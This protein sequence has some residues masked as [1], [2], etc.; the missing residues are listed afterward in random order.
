MKK[1]TVAKV[2][3]NL[4]ESNVCAFVMDHILSFCPQYIGIKLNNRYKKKWDKKIVSLKLDLSNFFAY[5]TNYSDMRQF[6]KKLDAMFG[7]RNHKTRDRFVENLYGNR[8]PQELKKLIRGQSKQH[9]LYLVFLSPLGHHLAQQQ[10][11]KI[12]LLNECNTT[13]FLVDRCDT[14]D[15]LPSVCRR[16]LE[17]CLKCLSCWCDLG[18]VMKHQQRVCLY[19]Q[20]VGYFIDHRTPGPARDWLDQTRN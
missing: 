3:N 13:R 4:F 1:E 7:A 2:P 18:A 17:N 6:E 5:S 20:A 19:K 16:Y 9:H 12:V 11:S 15:F 10:F 14:E 8:C